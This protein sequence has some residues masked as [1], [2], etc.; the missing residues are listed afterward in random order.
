LRSS[1]S[2]CG[3]MAEGLY[4]CVAHLAPGRFDNDGPQERVL[5]HLPLPFAVSHHVPHEHSSKKP[6]RL[7]FMRIRLVCISWFLDGCLRQGYVGFAD[8]LASRACMEASWI[9]SLM[10]WIIFGTH[11]PRTSREDAPAPPSLLAC[12][13]TFCGLGV[14]IVRMDFVGSKREMSP[15]RPSHFLP[16][17]N[18][19]PQGS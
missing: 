4:T 10:R 14:V 8:L 13:R 12:L 11:D 9:L 18:R 2:A 16:Y 6:G 5:G 3:S 17:R 19:V 1:M 15:N 7:V